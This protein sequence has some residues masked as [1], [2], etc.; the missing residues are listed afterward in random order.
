MQRD[1][2]AVTAVRTSFQYNMA[3]AKRYRLLLDGNEENDHIPTVEELTKLKLKM[4]QA[5]DDYREC[6]K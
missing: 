1:R 5:S 2:F 6:R 3:R 4:Y